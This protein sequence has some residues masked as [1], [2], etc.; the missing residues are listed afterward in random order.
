VRRCTDEGE[1]GG[2]YRW[3]AGTALLHD[4]AV[5][6]G[7]RTA[8]TVTSVSGGLGDIGLGEVFVRFVRGWLDR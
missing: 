6:V 3:E 5:A 1:P 2:G 7:S 4:E 8:G